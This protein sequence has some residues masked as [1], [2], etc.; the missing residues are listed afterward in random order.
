MAAPAGYHRSIVIAEGARGL[1]GEPDS[2]L[3]PSSTGE[4]GAI[5]PAADAGERL[6]L[7]AGSSPGIGLKR[8]LLVV[9]AGDCCS[10]GRGPGPARVLSRLHSPVRARASCTCSRSSS[11]RTG[12]AASSWPPPAPACFLYG[13]WR[14]VRV[15]MGPFLSTEGDQPLVTEVIY[16]KTV[17]VARTQS[18]RYRRQGLGLSMLLRGSRSTPATLR[19]WS[20][21]RTM[22]GS[23]GRLREEPGVSRRWRHP[24]LHRRPRGLGVADGPSCSAALSCH[25]SRATA[26]RASGGDTV[27]NLLLAAMASVQG[28]DFEEG[29]RQMK[30]R[31]GGPRPG[32][33][34][35]A[36]LRSRSTPGC[37]TGSR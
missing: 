35:H 30:P 20:R 33:A 6:R 2:G 37:S 13:S 28:D 22:G 17:P 23:S 32:G 1:A 26:R 18:G 15:L 19:R 7:R 36:A 34:G 10:P 27:G 25:A 24:Q 16:Q 5:E 11:C 12:S 8:W 31:A 3:L 29:V 21:S 14:A 4:L 9:F